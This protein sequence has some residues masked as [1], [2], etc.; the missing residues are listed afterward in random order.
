MHSRSR[1]LEPS[2]RSVFGH[3]PDFF[4]ECQIKARMSTVTRLSSQAML[5]SA[6]R[7]NLLLKLSVI[8]RRRVEMVPRATH[9]VL[10]W[11]DLRDL[12]Q[13]A[14]VLPLVLLIVPSRRVC[15]I[16]PTRQQ[17]AD[18]TTQNCG[19]GFCLS[20]GNFG[21]LSFRLSFPLGLAFSFAV[22]EW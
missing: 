13:H 18:R 19:L 4:V 21:A 1:C 12:T 6:T 10:R 3:F 17:A 7:I 22:Q 16:L 5:F 14:N 20:R 15:C 9:T 8:R 2:S 11:L